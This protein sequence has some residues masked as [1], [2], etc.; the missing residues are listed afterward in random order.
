MKP[1]FQFC[2]LLTLLLTNYLSLR[3]STRKLSSEDG[4]SNN[5]VYNICQDDLGVLYIGTLDGLNIWDGQKM[6]QFKAA[7]GKSYFE[8]NKIK[9]LFQTKPNV[10]FAH[11][12]HGLARIDIETREVLFMED[13]DPECVLDID[14]D[15]NIYAI[16]G[17]NL[18]YYMDKKSG[19]QQIIEGFSLDKYDEAV[20]LVIT[21]SGELF[22]FSEKGT[23]KITFNHKG[24]S[25]KILDVK[26]LNRI[27]L[28]IS[29]SHCSKPIYAISDD[30]KLSTFDAES[31]RFTEICKFDAPQDFNLT[32]ITGV[33]RAE[34]GYWIN[35]WEQLFY[36]PDGSNT[37]ETTEIRNH[38]FTIVHDRFQPILWIGTDSEGLVG[39]SYK[40]PDIRSI[41]YKEL[42]QKIS[43]PIRCIYADKGSNTLL[44]GTKGDG[45]FRIRNFSKNVEIEDM[46]IDRLHTDNSPLGDNSVYC[47]TESNNGC[48]L[49]GT[50]G[51]GLN[52]IEG[53]RLGIIP[54]SETL[55]Q[56][57]Q[58][59]QQNDST[60]WVVTGR[61]N[62]FRCRFTKTTSTPS[63]TSIDTVDFRSSF[64]ARTQIYDL[65]IQ[66]DSTIWFASKGHGYLI[67]NTNTRQS[68]VVQFPKKYGVA[69]N[70]V[71]Q[72]SSFGEMTFCTRNGI[73]AG[74]IHIPMSAKASLKDND[75]NIWVSTSTGIMVLDRQYNLIK[76][77]GKSSGLPIIEY[78]DRACFHDDKTGTL[79]FGG[80]NGLTIIDDDID[81]RPNE[82][83]PKINITRFL[84]NNE[85]LPM[86]R[87]LKDGI[88]ILPHSQSSFS[89]SFSAID[90]I[91]QHDYQFMYCLEGH[92]NKWHNIEG[93]TIT[94]SVLPSGNYTL[95]IRCINNITN[96]VCSECSLP[97]RITPPFYLTTVAF[98]IYAL[99]AIGLIAWVIIWNKR[100]AAAKQEAI[101]Q[102][103]RARIQ[104]IKT[105]TSA[106]IS[107]DISVTTTFI[108]G[109]CQQIQSRAANIPSISEKVALVEQ[110]V[111]K[112]GRTLDT[113]SELRKISEN[114]AEDNTTALISVSRVTKE[115]LDLTMASNKDSEI[116]LN[117][118]IQ[119][120]V[121][122]D[123][124]NERFVTM[125]NAVTNAVFSL[126][127]PK[128]II[129]FNLS[130]HGYGQVIM[131]FTFTTDAARYRAF[132][133]EGEE[134]QSCGRL[135]EGLSAKIKHSY[136]PSKQTATVDLHLQTAASKNSAR[137]AD[138]QD[139]N[140]PH[141][142][143]MFI[144]SKNTEITSFLKY[145]TSDR[146][147]ISVYDN[148]DDIISSIQERQPSVII[149]DASSLPGQI[150]N[151]METLKGSKKL[152]QTPVISL[153]S[154]LATIEKDMCLKA[155]SDLC[156][157][158][159]FNVETFLSSLDRLVGRKEKAA[160]YYS[161]P[162]S[163]F[164]L[165]E[166]KAMHKDELAFIRKIVQIIDANMSDPKLSTTMIAEQ[167]GISTRVLYR[168]IE[169]L[170]EKSLR[171]IIIE[172]R[173]RYAAKLLIST[174]LNIDEIMYKT[175]HDNPSTFYR[176]FKLFHGV[177]T[178]EYRKNLENKD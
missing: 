7:D 123:I 108:L 3:A 136:S 12:R 160:E 80:I 129:S 118:D 122:L 34:N 23:R 77:Y 140:N 146:Y 148:N 42:S 16:G 37:L 159:P 8:G 138:R 32:R 178:K 41:T 14:D 54:G 87:V 134:L 46:N 130:R 144:I 175:G 105:D 169:H 73:I 126:T 168:K 33:V 76:S 152:S 27:Y 97:I 153:T 104:K 65:E 102:Q 145:F 103:Y 51:K 38:S 62:A 119:E 28:Y 9:H 18:L 31:G 75:G 92:D 101:R 24:A 53:N 30:C 112:I 113:W 36:L 158:F 2:I 106:A 173:M 74:D 59:A 67:Y 150:T 149:Y 82:Y 17:D 61:D 88:L 157:A 156:L 177:T 161:S 83:K 125:F 120:N 93:R 56:V 4:L 147:N 26:D 22:V 116:K 109:L 166:G 121:V 6:E 139:V 52:Y 167:M 64:K 171:N 29:E 11:T 170:T 154:S 98:I 45:L 35:L 13:F 96:E 91:N 63:I 72:I 43:M 47:I 69:I 127:G 89:L 90:H 40:D 44:L 20:R 55:Y 19:R 50:E 58:I 151:F 142:D 49:I 81:I 174:K 86:S 99:L 176:N 1:L 111:G 117:T 10:I 143:N 39:W 110:N 131:S 84:G 163:S 25:P 135:A 107:E 21:R 94:F 85:D 71:T 164:V 48:L 95:R 5:A 141:H 132:A 165:E 128:G 100:R 172:S 68:Q 79:F 15:E 155:G 70:E 114:P 133:E 124:A 137:A 60:L 115:I 66:N 78:S 57:H 162:D